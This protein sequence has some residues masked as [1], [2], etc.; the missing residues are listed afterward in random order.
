MITAFGEAISASHTTLE[1]VRQSVPAARCLSQPRACQCYSPVSVCWVYEQGIA[2]A[3][4]RSG[5]F[6]SKSP[7][8]TRSE[9]VRK[10]LPPGYAQL[11]LS[12][13]IFTRRALRS[14]ARF[15]LQSG[16]DQFGLSKNVCTMA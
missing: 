9:Q 15:N 3:K 16:V 14:G 7:R 8:I 4:V 13:E 2:A 12:P 6:R 1:V 11:L 5:T 10:T